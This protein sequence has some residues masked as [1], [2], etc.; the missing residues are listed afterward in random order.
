MGPVASRIFVPNPRE[1][2][3]QLNFLRVADLFDERETERERE[4]EC[5]C[6]VQKLHSFLR[7]IHKCNFEDSHPS[8]PG[9]RQ[10]C[11]GA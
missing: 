6:D 4:R 3:Q 11:V 8:I 2:A 7:R 9:K 10:T 5:V 1:E